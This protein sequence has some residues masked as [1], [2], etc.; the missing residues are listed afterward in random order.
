MNGTLI[1][2]SGSSQSVLHLL[3]QKPLSQ[4]GSGEICGVR[5]GGFGAFPF[6]KSHTGVANDTPSPTGRGAL[7]RIINGLLMRTLLFR[8]ILRKIRIIN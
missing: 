6:R 7:L 8:I 4:W 2:H 5:G 3:A 1:L